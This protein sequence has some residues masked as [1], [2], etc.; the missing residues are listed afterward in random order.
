MWVMVTGAEVGTD[1]G[2]L[3][4]RVDFGPAVAADV[5]VG[6]GNSVGAGVWVG[7]ALAAAVGADAGAGAQDAS[8]AATSMKGI[9]STGRFLSMGAFIRRSPEQWMRCPARDDRRPS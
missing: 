1:V 9:Q 6:M 5:G 2:G 7:A 8:A 3:G 4:A